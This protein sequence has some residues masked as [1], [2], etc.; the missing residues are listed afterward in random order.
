MFEP[1]LCP[2][3]FKL[4]YLIKL[5]FW[6]PK[7]FFFSDHQKWI[8]RFSTNKNTL[9]KGLLI[10]FHLRFE[11]CRLVVMKLW[12]DKMLSNDLLNW[13]T[14]TTNKI[15]KL[16]FVLDRMLKN[17]VRF[18]YNKRFHTKRYFL[19]IDKLMRFYY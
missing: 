8:K 13:F 4:K 7:L 2:P 14:A 10:I 3:K 12:Y 11:G 15:L 9:I 18:T 5:S 16:Y 17:S 6:C 19:P 1:F